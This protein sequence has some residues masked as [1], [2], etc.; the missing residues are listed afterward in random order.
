MSLRAAVARAKRNLPDAQK[1]NGP[2]FASGSPDGR[3]VPL[4]SPI[5]QHMSSDLEHAEPLR[6]RP[7]LQRRLS[8]TARSPDPSSAPSTMP[9]SKWSGAGLYWHATFWSAISFLR[10]GNWPLQGGC[11]LL[12]GCAGVAQELFQSESF[13][14]PITRG[15]LIAGEDADRRKIIEQNHGRYLD[16]PI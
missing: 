14:L 3:A 7:L 16:G 11:N 10:C 1:P 15:V 2:P 4:E 6:K 5:S 13:W 8:D 9:T 12:L